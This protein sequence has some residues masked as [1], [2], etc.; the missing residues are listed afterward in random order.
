[1]RKVIF[2]T[3]ISIVL[4]SIAGCIPHTNVHR[5]AHTYVV[6]RTADSGLATLRECMENA[7]S[8]DTITFDPAVFPPE[9]PVTIALQNNLP[10]I[11]CG[12]LTID[13][14]E[15][16][17]ILD[18]GQTLQC[19]LSVQSSNNTIRGLQIVG[20]S[21]FG[22]SLAEGSSNNIIGGNRTIGSGLMGQGN[23]IS[24][25][26]IGIE[27]D[28][29]CN[30]VVGNFIGTD[31]GGLHAFDHGQFFFSHG[32]WILGGSYNRI[33]GTSPGERN[34]ISANGGSGV[35]MHR[36]SGNV[37]V[38]NFIGTDVNGTVDLGNKNTGVLI[39]LGS[40]HNV[41]KSNLISGSNWGGVVISDWASSYNTVVGNLIGTDASGTQA[42]GNHWTGVA[43]GWGG[44]NFNRI[45]GT[46]PGDGNIISGNRDGISLCGTGN[47]IIGNFIGTNISGTEAIS[48]HQG[49]FMS[50]ESN[51]NFV[52]GTTPAERNVISAAER[53]GIWMEGAELNFII[54]NYIGTDVGG[55][56]ALDN[57]GIGIDSKSGKYNVIQGNLI[58]GNQEAGVQIHGSAF[59]HLRANRIGVAVDGASPL[60][61]DLGVKIVAASNTV[62]GLYPEDGNIIAFNTGDG[63]QVWTYSG[64]TIRHNSIYS[65]YSGIHLCDGGNNL[66]AAPIITQV[67]LGYVSGTACPGCIVEIF[68]DEDDE[69][70]VYEGN[71]IADSNGNW[72]WEGSVTGP[73]VTA[74]ATDEAG[75]TSAF[76]TPQIGRQH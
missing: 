51:H 16:G 71:V 53:A 57:Q 34:I 59:N 15:A 58:A 35:C 25:N 73:H 27:I 55:T 76:S 3:V 56:V 8:G 60:P 5:T 20:F 68:S 33:G 26:R 14:S 7:I 2:F 46:S 6:T 63:V 19:G 37:V 13:A 61:N 64:N 22:I 62:G 9:S 21:V 32:V 49:I 42:L 31:V 30:T 40:F 48:N 67:L 74:T 72:R 28:G 43:V 38:G 17:V 45:G 70:R 10:A 65:N 39:E 69:G 4:F 44:A 52:G 12:N 47:L 36:A 54:G 24:G 66:L 50:S 75:N 18:G 11:Y 23:L 29:N 41:V 1:M